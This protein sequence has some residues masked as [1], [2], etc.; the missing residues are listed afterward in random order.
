MCPADLSDNVP[1]YQSGS[2]PD[3]LHG[4]LFDI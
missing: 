1:D 3:Y 4:Y 2:L